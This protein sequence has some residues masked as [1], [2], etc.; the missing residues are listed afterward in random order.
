MTQS[1]NMEITQAKGIILTGR[2]RKNFIE[3]VGFEMK[4]QIRWSGLEG[5][6]GGGGE[7]RWE[8]GLKGWEGGTTLGPRSSAA[9]KG[10]RGTQEGEDLPGLNCGAPLCQ[11]VSFSSGQ[12]VTESEIVFQIFDEI[13]KKSST[14]QLSTFDPHYSWIRYLHVCLLAKIGLWCPN[15]KPQGVICRRVW[16]WWKTGSHNARTPSGSQT[17]Q[18]SVFLCQLPRCKLGASCGLLHA[19]FFQSDVLF[20]D[21]FAF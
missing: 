17:R 8:Q 11:E 15:Q 6:N 19:S 16:S 21:D 14:I 9:Q 18:Y 4:A 2:L 13:P 5:G 12:G 3:K 7:R 1:N 20:A 10:S